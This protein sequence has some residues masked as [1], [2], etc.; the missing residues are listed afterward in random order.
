MHVR[1]VKYAHTALCCCAEN[2]DGSRDRLAR[3]G[4]EAINRAMAGYMGG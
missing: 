3:R 1:R 2:E 4:F